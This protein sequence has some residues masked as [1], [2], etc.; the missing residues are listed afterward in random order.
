MFTVNNKDTRT[1]PL[2]MR[3]LHTFAGAL[4][5]TYVL[6]T[7]YA[8]TKSGNEGLKALILSC[9]MSQKCQTHFKNIAANAG[10]F[11]QCV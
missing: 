9:I 10:R 7:T 2:A 1:T 5:T 4:Y 3:G 6:D 11:V 8:S